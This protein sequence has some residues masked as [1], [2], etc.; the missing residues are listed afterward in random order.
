M[1]IQ[2]FHLTKVH[3]S[4]VKVLDDVFLSIP[5]G[6]F[7]AI[8][9][10]SRTGKSTLLKMLGGEEEPTSG[11]LRVDHLDLYGLSEKDKQKWLSE[12]GMIFPDLKLF[13][14][15]TV[16]ENILFTLRVKG[17]APEGGREAILKLLSKAGLGEKAQAKPSDL[18][19]GEQRMVMALRAMIFRPRLLLADEPFQG[20]DAKAAS[21]LFRFLVE[22]NK[23]GCTIVLSTQQMSFLEEAKKV[24]LQG[25]IQWL[26]MEEGKLHSLEEAAP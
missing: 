24:S 5:D 18:S 15:K 14:D 12:V 20:L 21:V 11:T 13:P 8:I 22:L 3:S 7:A 17:A 2:A 1:M 10:E 23:T 4:G 25:A 6:A 9:G 16:E 19:S 26:K